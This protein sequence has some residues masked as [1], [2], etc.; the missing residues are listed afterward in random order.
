MAIF[1][2]MLLTPLIVSIGLLLYWITI[3]IQ[4]RDFIAVIIGASLISF[5]I[6][7]IGIFL[8]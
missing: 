5:V 8:G 6:G 3:S 4:D 1:V 7:S 2:L